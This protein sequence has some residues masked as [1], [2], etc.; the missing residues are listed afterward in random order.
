MREEKAARSA[1]GALIT[2]PI[3]FTAVFFTLGIELA[4]TALFY[5][6]GCAAIG[7]AAGWFLGKRHAAIQIAASALLAA[8]LALVPGISVP[9]ADIIRI[10]MAVLGA[11]MAV[12]MERRFISPADSLS[13][14][15]LLSPLAVLLVLSAVLLISAHTSGE[16]GSGVWTFIISMGTAWFVIA[17]FM[18][19]RTALRQAAHAQ[20]HGEVPPGARRSG[21]AG[22]IVFLAAAFAL[23]NIE[24]IVS[25]IG[26]VIRKL[27]EWLMAAIAFF[28]SLFPKAEPMPEPTQEAAQDLF[29]PAESAGSPIWD[30]ILWILAAALLLAAA[31]GIIYGLYKWIPK[32]WRKL[33]ERIGNL[34]ATWREEEQDYSDRSESLMSLRQAFANAGARF[35]KV[36]RRRLRL[37]DFP[38]NAGKAR[39][40]FREFLHGLVSSGR[41]PPPGATATEIARPAPALSTAYNQARYGEEEPSD[42]EIEKARESVHL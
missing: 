10:A 19:N 27:I 8:A 18:L 39:F 22:V 14:G 37:S 6:F 4:R 2:L 20:T 36:F 32:L 23:A 40:L 3:A 33:K 35:R 21:T 11:L 28:G 1:A 38:T 30:I 25:F 12:W 31:C 26:A 41:E 5:G 24:A 42:A 13:P 15:L 7:I 9:S 34:F 16:A 29:P 17:V